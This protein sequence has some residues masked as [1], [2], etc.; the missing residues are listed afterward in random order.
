MHSIWRDKGMF[1]ITEQRFMDQQ[2]QIRKKKWLTKLELKEIQRT[3]DDEP[4]G[5][6]PNDSKSED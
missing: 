4:H 3:I 1:N 5:H 6:L 2:C